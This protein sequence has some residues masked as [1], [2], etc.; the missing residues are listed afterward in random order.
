LVVPKLPSQDQ[1]AAPP[2]LDELLLDE[3]LLPASQLDLHTVTT[4][5]TQV[6]SQL[7][8]QQ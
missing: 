7:V 6:L 1:L 4:S 5:P 8:L 3:L 2:L